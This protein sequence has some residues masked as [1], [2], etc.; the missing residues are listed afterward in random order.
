MGSLKG[1]RRGDAKPARG[2]SGEGGGLGLWP[3]Q[4]ESGLCA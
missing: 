2:A 4:T 3:G 1:V